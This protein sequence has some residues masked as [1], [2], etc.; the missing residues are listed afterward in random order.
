MREGENN[1]HREYFQTFRSE[2]Q[3]L[4]L[5]SSTDVDQHD[6]Y[7]NYLRTR[8]RT[9]KSDRR[10]P[11]VLTIAFEANGGSPDNCVLNR[12]NTSTI[13]PSVT[14]AECILLNHSYV[15]LARVLGNLSPVGSYPLS[16]RNG[17]LGFS[18]VS[19]G[20]CDAVDLV[21]T[22]IRARGQRLFPDVSTSQRYGGR[23]LFQYSMT[24]TDRLSR[25]EWD[26]AVQGTNAQVEIIES[27]AVD[28][29]HIITLY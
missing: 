2:V 3:T 6:N 8:I 26:M 18:L 9:I 17:N 27:D 7:A 21:A 5:C 15:P 22:L 20:E 13:E 1:R 23:W 4:A 12:I 14:V 28:L 19:S 25:E 11:V 29:G 16:Q 24:T 10:L